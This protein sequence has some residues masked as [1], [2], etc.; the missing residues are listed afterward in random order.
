MTP[1]LKEKLDRLVEA[2]YQNEYIDKYLYDRNSI[3]W[4]DK[5]QAFMKEKFG[6]LWNTYWPN[7]SHPDRIWL[8]YS[9][10]ERAME[11][12]KQGIVIDSSRDYWEYVKFKATEWEYD[13]GDQRYDLLIRILGLND[14]DYIELDDLIL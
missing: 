13:K 2:L 6:E 5:G 11:Q 10:I 1:E 8:P 7:Y 12:V 14:I 4:T 3:N 9:S